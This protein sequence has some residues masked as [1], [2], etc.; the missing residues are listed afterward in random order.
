MV[1][2]DWK[3]RTEKNKYK[4]DK[5]KWKQ[6]ENRDS[7]RPW[8]P[9]DGKK[10]KDKADEEP[11]EIQDPLSPPR[12]ENGIKV[13]WLTNIHP[14]TWNDPESGQKKT[15]L[16]M[17]FLQED[18][19]TFR[20]SLP[21][22]PYFYVLVKE[23]KNLLEVEGYLRRKFER[24][25]HQVEIERVEKDDLDIRN[26][27]SGLRRMCL[28]LSFLTV[29]TLV[30]VR[31][32][33]A[34]IVKRNKDKVADVFDDSLVS[35]MTSGGSSSSSVRRG[36]SP[37]QLI[38]ELRE[39]D[40]PYYVRVSIDMGVRVANWYDVSVSG[41]H[42]T[43]THRKDLVGRPDVRVL[44]FDIETTK[45]PLKFPDPAIDQI[46][47]ISYMLDG[48]GYLIVNREIVSEDIPDF[49][50]KYKD[51]TVPFTMRNEKDEKA[52]LTRFYS[53]VRQ[54]KPTIFVT[55]NGGAPRYSRP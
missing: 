1:N 11:E 36:V 44:A 13:G 40:V 18:G 15:C 55:F 48:Q 30:G 43:L 3:K 6:K 37:E 53:H 28:K 10:N 38:T 23:D 34:G 25:N 51:T 16:E 8:T 42:V 5:G 41:G 17:Y 12:L 22:A 9:K 14:H 50:Y 47:M 7:N 24:Q 2:P 31:N 33:L 45:L 39:Y 27:L 52:L 26:H 20:A 32:D 49:D 29:N 54:V 4:N 46:M 19:A 21:F 35:Q